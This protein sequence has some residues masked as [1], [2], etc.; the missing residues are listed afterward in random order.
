MSL[1][2]WIGRQFDSGGGGDTKINYTAS[3]EQQEVYNAILPMLQRLGVSATRS[4]RR[5]PYMRLYNQGVNP[6]TN[7]P[8]NAR[9]YNLPT[10]S[11]GYQRSATGSNTNQLLA[12][13]NIN[14]KRVEQGLKPIT[15]D[16]LRSGQMRG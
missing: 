4:N 10:A 11:R 15:L 6:A 13:A 16:Q 9:T 12:L 2:D 8:L 3:P 14:K 5:D 1:L 7:R